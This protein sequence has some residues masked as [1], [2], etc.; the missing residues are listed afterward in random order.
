MK[1]KNV[2][3]KDFVS[4]RKRIEGEKHDCTVMALAIVTNQ[5]YK[6][7]HKFLETSGRKFGEGFDLK[8]SLFLPLP[9]EKGGESYTK[10]ITKYKN[11]KVKTFINNCDK[12]QNFLII[13]KNHCLAFKKGKIYDNRNSSNLLIDEI[14]CF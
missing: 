1:Q 6:K 7:T 4:V 8:S 10:K 9:Y 12:T 5:T 11:K 2:I 13:T 14:L 3:F